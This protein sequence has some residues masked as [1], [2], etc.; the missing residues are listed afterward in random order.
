MVLYTL[1]FKFLDS[2]LEDRFCTEFSINIEEILQVPMGILKS[3]IRCWSLLRLLLIIA[4]L[5]QIIIIVNE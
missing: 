3:K 5:M 1:I 2:K 4:L